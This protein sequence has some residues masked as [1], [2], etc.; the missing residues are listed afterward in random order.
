MEKIFLGISFK[1]NPWLGINLCWNDGEFARVELSFLGFD[2][3]GISFK[4]S[5]EK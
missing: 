3:F 4:R 5:K 1:G 2:L